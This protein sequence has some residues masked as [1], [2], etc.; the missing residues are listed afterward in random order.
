MGKS[1][2]S[3]GESR[4]ARRQRQ[5]IEQGRGSGYRSEYRPFIQIE[6]GG[7]QSHGR[8]HLVYD[9]RVGRSYHLMSDLELL[10]FLWAWSL[11]AVD[12]REQFP[13]QPYE[14]DFEFLGRHGGKPRGTQAIAKALGI[15]HPQ[16]QR[17]VPRVMT[18]DLVVSFR[19]KTKIAIHAKYKAELAN[20]TARARDLRKIEKQYWIDRGVRFLVMDEQPFTQ[21][22]AN[23][24]MWAIDGMKWTADEACTERIIECLDK[25]CVRL[26]MNE[27]LAHCASVIGIG[28]CE[29]V[30][31][32]KYA[33]ITRRWHIKQL[34]QEL[35]LS[36]SWAGK[37]YRRRSPA[38]SSSFQ[39]PG[40]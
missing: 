21:F 20:A 23:Q 1:L 18:T 5:F 32:F 40:K 3:T 25:T 8:S 29:A 7:F 9:E 19:D 4:E 13:L 30:R 34:D 39:V 24:M 15:R 2:L 33:V 12:W 11:D 37:R 10:I 38:T 6:R 17:N 26:S 22:V 35:D 28:Q 14:F 36:C 16:I 31:G 27:R